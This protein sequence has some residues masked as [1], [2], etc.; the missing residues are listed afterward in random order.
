MTLRATQPLP[1]PETPPGPAPMPEPEPPPDQWPVRIIDLP[2]DSPTR[3]IPVPQ[4]EHDRR[5]R[6]HSPICPE[7]GPFTYRR[8][9]F[10]RC[11]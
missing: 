6:A 10:G 5:A 1:M 11:I 7:P 2:P 3:G 4:P 9:G 8:A